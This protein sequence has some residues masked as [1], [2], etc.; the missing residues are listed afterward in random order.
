[1]PKTKNTR[2]SKPAKSKRV[3]QLKEYFK[4]NT[5]MRVQEPRMGKPTKHSSWATF[6]SE[7]LL[8]TYHINWELGQK[9][10]KKH[11]AKNSWVN[12][13]PFHY[14]TRRKW[15]IIVWPAY[16]SLKKREEAAEKL[17]WV[18]K[19]R[20][21]LGGT[22]GWGS[23]G[24]WGVEGDSIAHSSL[25]QCLFSVFVFIIFINT[26]LHIYVSYNFFFNSL[27]KRHNNYWG[28]MLGLYVR[29]V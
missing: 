25:R 26:D 29:G 15:L 22:E 16:P 14:I 6:N 9:A 2:Y 12:K 28:E 7:R 17:S 4:S 24:G 5:A 11:F 10:F 18:M 27:N 20:G 3:P 19:T 1:M 21:F 8:N 23:E 13:D